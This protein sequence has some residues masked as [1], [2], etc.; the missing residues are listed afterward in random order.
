MIV[1]GHDVRMA[2][3]AS[4]T[5]PNAGAPFTFDFKFTNNWSSVGP[6]EQLVLTDV[7]PTG[8]TL[9]QLQPLPTGG[10]GAWNCSFNAPTVTCTFATGIM[11]YP[12]GDATSTPPAFPALSIAVLAPMNAGSY[13]N[14]ADLDV[15]L[16]NGGDDVPQNNTHRC[17]TIVVPG[18][19]D[20][21]KVSD[22]TEYNLGAPIHF[23]VTVTNPPA[24]RPYLAAS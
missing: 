18:H 16:N 2:K 19:L 14:C 4:N 21:A 13:E 9:N 1:V 12:A 8:V 22:H 10:V 3:S 6:F 20:V 24:P 7:L 23:T 11:V 5:T 15:Q 17:V